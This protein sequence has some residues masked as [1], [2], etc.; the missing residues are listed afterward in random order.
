LDSDIELIKANKKYGNGNQDCWNE[1][2]F[3]D[4][5]NE[6]DARRAVTDDVN[7]SILSNMGT[8]VTNVNDAMHIIPLNHSKK[9]DSITV[10]I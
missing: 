8:I 5:R 2:Y 7:R 3:L 6:F 9:N 4:I 10:N 1:A